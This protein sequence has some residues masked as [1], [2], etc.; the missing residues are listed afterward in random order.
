[1]PIQLNPQNQT[2]PQIVNNTNFANTSGQG[3]GAVIPSEIK[4]WCWGAFFWGLIWAI[5]NKV[6][7]G[8]LGL[9][10][11]VG[12]IMTLVLGYKGKEWAWQSHKWDSVEHFNKVQH[13]WAVWGIVLYIL[14]FLA[15][16]SVIF[17]VLLD[18][19]GI[20]NKY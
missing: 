13:R 11:Y 5:S 19:R 15:V 6:W 4:G 12:F 10:P 7:I 17:L 8:L 20:I 18:P 2:A 3:K 14:A 16:G 1:M 9:I